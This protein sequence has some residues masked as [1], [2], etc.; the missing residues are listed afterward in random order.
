MGVFLTN[1]TLRGVAPQRVSDWLRKNERQVF[2]S[3]EVR[4]CTVVCDSVCDE[5]E[6]ESLAELG[7]ALSKDLKCPALG[8]MVHD[9][10]V[11]ILMLFEQGRVVMDY[12]SAPS[13]FEDVEPQ[14]PSGADAAALCRAFGSD[15]VA[16]VEQILN[17]WS[18]P[19]VDVEAD[20][21]ESAFDSEEMRLAALAKALGLPEAVAVVSYV[22]LQE[23]DIDEL[24]EDAPSFEEIE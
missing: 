17:Q 16:E 3:G 22:S 12:N 4:G 24:G 18:D 8:A 20:F 2:V 6:P 15:R 14:A 7:A 13:Y 9:S 19:E 11:L 1:I 23:G 21:D 5:Q 10:D